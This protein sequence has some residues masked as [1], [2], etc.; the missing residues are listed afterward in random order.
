MSKNG[1]ML[2]A[3]CVKC[4]CKPCVPCTA[5]CD[6]N[7]PVGF[8]VAYSGQDDVYIGSNVSANPVN[9]VPTPAGPFYA[10]IVTIGQVVGGALTM[11][12]DYLACLFRLK[13][14]RNVFEKNGTPSEAL[15]KQTLT[16]RC[17][18]G[19]IWVGDFELRAG[20]SVIYTTEP[21]TLVEGI[22][23]YVIKLSN[24]FQAVAGLDD[25][26]G[27][28][29]RY[30]AAGAYA[31]CTPASVSVSARIEWTSPDIHHVLYGQ[32]VEC[33][34]ELP[35]EDPNNCLDCD[36]TATPAPE[37]VYL[38]ISNFNG[39]GAR[40]LGFGTL[41]LNGTYALSLAPNAIACAHYEG[42]LP[43][44]A[45]GEYCAYIA[46][47]RIRVGYGGML[48]D[49]ITGGHPTNTLY[50]SGGI[51]YPLSMEKRIGAAFSFQQWQD[52]LCDGT[53]ISGSVSF[54]WNFQCSAVDTDTDCSFD[55]ELST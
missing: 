15:S 52:L 2:G 3:G 11:P 51:L 38:E 39:D 45:V 24:I 43:I 25:Q 40:T 34:D 4:G 54:R 48:F 41:N 8:T 36:G 23:T 32:L 49:A 9:V 12:S 14:W 7:T 47:G 44:N 42:D 16:I 10:E 30:P 29:P 13:I 6:P 55:W 26:S 33:F 22:Y 28:P 27:N 18:Q 50:S 17:T 20:E 46:Q 1:L 37:T 5:E 31:L 19:K 21:E 53:P 35:P